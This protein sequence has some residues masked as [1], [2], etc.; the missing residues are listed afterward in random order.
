VT[1]HAGR[2]CVD[3]AGAFDGTTDVMLDS[4]GPV[5]ADLAATAVGCE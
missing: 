3:G 4:A 2:A 5:R 1:I